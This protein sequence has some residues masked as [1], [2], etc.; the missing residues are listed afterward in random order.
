MIM[1]M[2][3]KVFSFLVKTLRKSPHKLNK[4]CVQYASWVIL[5]LVKL[6]Y[7]FIIT[8]GKNNIWIDLESL[9]SYS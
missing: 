9:S 4:K 5:N 3:S 7:I 8:W 6:M 2:F 1:P